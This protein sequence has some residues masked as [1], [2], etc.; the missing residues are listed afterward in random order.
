MVHNFDYYLI[1]EK[2]LSIEAVFVGENKSKI[3]KENGVFYSKSSAIDLINH[4]CIRFGSTM[5]GRIDAAKVF[6]SFPHKTPF[7]IIPFLLGV[8]PTNSRKNLT[9]VW[10]FNHPFQITF[11]EK[12]KSR[13]TFRNGKSIIVPVSKH[14]LTQQ[15]QRLHAVLDI[16]NSK[17]R[18][19]NYSVIKKDRYNRKK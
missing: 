13:V 16:Y 14:S 18:N 7:I 17:H 9:C 19:N 15:K 6:S 12:K 3:T 2:V 10:I 8:F 4:A 11:L 5:Q 1:D